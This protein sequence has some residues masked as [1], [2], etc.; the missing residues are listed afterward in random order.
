[1]HKN[2]QI[3]KSSQWLSIANIKILDFPEKYESFERMGTLTVKNKCREKGMA[4]SIIAMHCGQRSEI[5]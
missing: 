4:L 1:M 3:N 5:D 2:G